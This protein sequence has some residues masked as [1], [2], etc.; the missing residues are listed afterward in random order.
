M[1]DDRWRIEPDPGG[2][3]E[4]AHP[5]RWALSGAASGS[6]GSRAGWRVHLGIVSSL[7]Y[8]TTDSAQSFID[9]G[10]GIGPQF[11]DQLSAGVAVSVP[12]RSRWLVTPDLT[13]LAQGEGRLD[14]PFPIGPEFTATPELFLG[15]VESTVRLGLT[16]S[17]GAGPLQL[18]GTGGYFHTTDFNHQA[19]R[20]RNRLEGRVR[21]TVGFA[22]G[23]V[24]R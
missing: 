3:G 1:I 21:A 19:G 20:T 8:R 15:R 22:T 16:V 2:T 18:S 23:A 10:V 17:G 14:A 6:L 13:L 12:V 7:A 24:I 9:R 5:G 11:P 4:P